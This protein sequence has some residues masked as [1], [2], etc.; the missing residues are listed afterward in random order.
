MRLILFTTLHE[1][2]FDGYVALEGYNSGIG[3]FAF[4][5]GMFHN[6][7]PDG[8]AFVRQGIGFLR[9]MEQQTRPR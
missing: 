2:G 4:E 1:I 6:V 9:Q 7:C 5:R 3:D 8:P